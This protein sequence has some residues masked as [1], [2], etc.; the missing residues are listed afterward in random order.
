M[1]IRDRFWPKL[2]RRWVLIV[3]LWILKIRMIGHTIRLPNYKKSCLYVPIF[4]SVAHFSATAWPIWTKPGRKVGNVSGFINKKSRMIG[5]ILCIPYYKNRLCV[6]PFVSPL[7]CKWLFLSNRSVDLYQS[8]H[9]GGYWQ[10]L[11]KFWKLGWFV[12]RSGF[13]IIKTAVSMCLFSFLS[14][15]SQQPL[16]RFGPILAGR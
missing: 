2:A 15:I 8:W 16:G 11:L 4:L 12:K 6:C 10:C 13:H 1:C 14:P 7:Y 5:H 9:E 3:A